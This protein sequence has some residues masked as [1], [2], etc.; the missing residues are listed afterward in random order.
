MLL[1]FIGMDA[2]NETYW[3]DVTHH[4]VVHLHYLLLECVP[5]I[6]VYGW[7]LS[8]KDPN[9]TCWEFDGLKSAKRTNGCIVGQDL[10]VL[11]AHSYTKILTIP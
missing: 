8:K 1:P 9:F 5:G 10:E 11:L 6:L 3:G 2:W 7:W 4:M